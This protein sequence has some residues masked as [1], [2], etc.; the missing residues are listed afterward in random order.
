[1]KMEIYN[2]MKPYGNENYV[3]FCDQMI[4]NSGNVLLKTVS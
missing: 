4:C 1:M 2:E 3:Q